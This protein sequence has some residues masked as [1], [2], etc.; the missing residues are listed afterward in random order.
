MIPFDSKRNQVYACLAHGRGAVEKHFSHVEDWQRETSLYGELSGKLPLPEVLGGEPGLLVTAY[1][2]QPTLLAVLEEQERN[3]F[4]PAPWIALAAWLRRCCALCG[5]L[6]RDGNLRDFLWDA[7][8]G[9]VVGLDLEGYGPCGLTECGGDFIASVLTYETPDTPVKGRIAALLAET[10]DVPSAA[11][12]RSR[13]RIKRRRIQRRQEPMSGVVLAGGRSRRMGESK[14][15]LLLEGKTFLLWQ[16]EKLRALGIQDIMLSGAGCPE[17]PGTRRLEDVYPGRGPLGGLHA[18]LGAAR[19]KRCLVVTVDT[20]LLPTACLA[21][22]CRAHDEGVTALRHGGKTEP[23]IAVYDSTL[24]QVIQPMIEAESAPVRQLE[25]KARW[26]FF[27]CAGPEEL[28]L[29]CNTP[30]DYA[31]L[32]TTA[33]AYRSEG[34][35]L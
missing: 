23:L 13:E 18:C 20:P 10:L 28:F 21:H 15:G 26:R 1:L 35:P 25:S 9:Q 24:S 11:M 6:P 16:A 5:K 30:E 33:A 7:G 32:Q 4:F 19:Y 29:N 8:A 22:L 17:V 34:L 3:G 14:A 2:P 27:D 31:R 12:E